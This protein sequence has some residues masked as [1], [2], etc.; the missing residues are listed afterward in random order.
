MRH[1]LILSYSV[2]LLILGTILFITILSG[3]SSNSILYYGSFDQSS[4]TPAFSEN[5]S[6][7]YLLNLFGAPKLMLMLIVGCGF[8][9]HLIFLHIL[10]KPKKLSKMVTHN[11]LA[12]WIVLFAPYLL[13]L[14]FTI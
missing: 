6:D 5:V 4:F 3:R 14:V 13:L 2:S 7:S 9:L 12:F 1:N 8:L 11:Y 10:T